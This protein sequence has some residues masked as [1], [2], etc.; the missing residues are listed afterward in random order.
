[1]KHKFRNLVLTPAAA[2]FVVGVVIT[3][4]P[5]DGNAPAPADQP[6]PLTTTPGPAASPVSTYEVFGSGEAM[7]TITTQGT[8]SNTVQLPSSG[9]LPDGFATVAVTRSP[10]VESYMQNGGADSGE[11]GC[12]IIRDGKVIDE[13]KSSGQFASVTC[14][15]FK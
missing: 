11:V 13:Q 7:V 5:G 1:M 2:L 3:A 8:S 15:K 14:S 9:D 4:N 6:T 10:S 12:R